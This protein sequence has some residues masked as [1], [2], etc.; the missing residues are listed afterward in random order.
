MKTTFPYGFFIK[1]EIDLENLSISS[2]APKIL[3]DKKDIEKIQPY[4]DSLNKTIKQKGI[5]NIALTGG[6][7]SGKSTIIKTFQSLNDQHEYLNISLASFNDVADGEGNRKAKK[8]E[9]ERLLEVSIL[10]QIFYHVKPSEIPDSRFKRIINVTDDRILSIAI[11][12]IFWVLSTLILFKFDYINKINPTTWNLNYFIDWIA[13]IVI[14]LFVTGIGLFAKSVI[15]LFS[16]SKINKFNIKGELE[17]GDNLDKSVF[18][19]HI[20]EIIYFFER[21]KYDVV[22]IE[23]LDRF[24]STDIF[25]K[26]REINI[27]LNNTK[28]ITREINFL[29]AIKDEMFNDNKERVKFFEYIIPVIPFINPSNAGDQLT[30][31]INE[32]DLKGVLSKDFTED[33]VTF[34]DDIDMRLL[35]NIFHEY[36]L[37]R[38]NLINDIDQDCLFAIITY[39]NLF[40]S[41][42]G[43][44]QKR[45]GELY[46]FLSK[47]NLYTIDLIKNIDDQIRI[48]Q[49]EAKSISS[50]IYDE[51]NE[52]KAIYIAEI[53]RQIPEATTLFIDE[54]ISFSNLSNDEEFD[55]LKE[56]QNIHYNYYTVYSPG[57][58]LFN[59]HKNISSNISF[60]D[61]E[62][63]I[64]SNLTF[65][66]RKSL[67][68]KKKDNR[69]NSLNEDIEKLKKNKIEIESWNLKQIFEEVDINKH[70]N[71]FS[72]N[73]L[74]RNL[75]LNGYINENY[76]DYI[77]LFHEVNLT[78][79]DY[80]FERKIK[81]GLYSP[82]DYNLSKIENVIKRI[83]EKYFNRDTILNFDILDFL[84]ENHD[85]Y[86]VKYS[87]IIKIL[88]NEK[89]K[90]IEFI[91]NYIDNRKN[92]LELF[93]KSLSHSWKGFWQY[94]IVESNFTKEK[95]DYYLEI[96]IKYTDIEDVIAFKDSNIGDYIERLPNF[97][98]M[99]NDN[100]YVKKTE[101]LFRLLD[102][103][104]KNLDQ[105]TENTRDLF[106]YVY[107]N[108][109]YEIN[110]ENILLMVNDA[111]LDEIEEDLLK[112]NYT[113]ILINGC[114]NLINYIEAN[115]NDYV[116]N[117]LLRIPDNDSESEEFIIELL[118]NQDLKDELKFDII[119][120][121]NLIFNDLSKIQNINIQ[122]NIIVNNKVLPTWVN[123]FTY[124]DK[125]ESKEF[126]E[127]LIKFFNENSNDLSKNKLE[128]DDQNSEGYIKD[129]SAELTKCNDL[130][131][132]CYIELVGNTTYWWSNI[133]INNLEYKK[134]EWLINNKKLSL[135][136]KN[137]NRL[138]E[139]FSTLHLKLLE[140]N[141]SS[142]II[143]FAD[144]ILD[145][146]DILILLKSTE[147]LST[148]KIQIIE[149]I[150][151]NIIIENEEIGKII[152]NLLAISNYIPLEYNV[153]ESLFI[154][155]NSIE[156]RIKLL[157]KHLDK[158][159]NTEIQNLI[160]F[161]GSSYKE[162]FKK[163]FKPKFSNT[164]FHEE[165]FEKL[166]SK[167]LILKKELDKKDKS[168]IKVFAKY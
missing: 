45:K 147:I 24:E 62:N 114:T 67:I 135:S 80:S 111:T 84:A 55:K 145:E 133:D 18:N 116:K 53:H 76:N 87:S 137:F 86:N 152:C 25:T 46:S 155:S 7:G 27:L 91:E 140:K 88:G 102:I 26:L 136:I 130:N 61:I 118:N 54:V 14:V 56:T 83:P 48:N 13:I 150:D 16:N 73:E 148:N 94:V 49:A 112:A 146:D 117:V 100:Q 115:I 124:Y 50:E 105:P 37:Y 22:I 63:S 59:E 165:L 31:M 96:I 106:N 79:D 104:F 101:D 8:E 126:N 123:I 11:G 1:E 103:K 162:I 139:H 132:D 81:S 34:I 40:P 121:Q 36:Q 3:T 71:G 161:L 157:N 164:P 89:K 19:E 144:Y 95:T 113:T 33:V 28:L 66:D 2:L 32:A 42:F 119:K 90:S 108:N 41:D 30:K 154:H 85:Q 51:I 43:N 82:F 110:M 39:K 38:K 159:S 15:R 65:D 160:E 141:Q 70:L 168:K 35:I 77:S 109:H 23:D 131:F 52:L 74:I 143:N 78:K 69:I 97:L 149:K 75:L 153:L 142:F 166:K 92:N 29:Y 151:D 163:Q 129:F 156:N 20:E 72:E 12:L 5:S 47:K 10:Q 122:E 58:Y 158:I 6:Y 138:K 17:L 120:K 57:H 107:E 21:T 127:V 125:L 64:N 167:N 9:L 60:S 98:S 134:T 128:K 68:K 93:I 99:L 4:L 44:L